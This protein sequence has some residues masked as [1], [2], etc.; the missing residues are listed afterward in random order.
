M[1]ML[2]LY[3]WKSALFSIHIIDHLVQKKHS[4]NQMQTSVESD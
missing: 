1:K 2:F 4:F 3:G